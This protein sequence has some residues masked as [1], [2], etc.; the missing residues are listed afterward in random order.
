MLRRTNSRKTG[1]SSSRASSVSMD[2]VD[3]YASMD[4]GTDKLPSIETAEASHVCSV[5]SVSLCECMC[6]HIWVGGWMGI[7]G[8]GV[9]V[10]EGEGG[11]GG[12][13][14]EIGGWVCLVGVGGVCGRAV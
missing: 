8:C 10:C 7:G 9:R 3:S 4:L 12:G 11:G 5:R 2:S 13:W 1:S 14:G 6:I